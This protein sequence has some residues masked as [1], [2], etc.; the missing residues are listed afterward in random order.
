MVLSYHLFLFEIHFVLECNADN[1]N[2]LRMQVEPILIVNCKPQLI[3][4]I[5]LINISP[6]VCAIKTE[7]C[8]SCCVGAEAKM[9]E[10]PYMLYSILFPSI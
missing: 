7:A 3:N 10:K 1:S 4:N 8:S 5:I 2:D 6:K 9:E